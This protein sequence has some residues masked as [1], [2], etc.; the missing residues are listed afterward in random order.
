M[1]GRSENITGPYVDK[2][3]FK[4]IY[5]GG[6]PFLIGN[7]DWPGVGH[8]GVYTFDNQDYIIYH[9]YDAR[10]HG[11][12]KLM[13]NKLGWDEDGWPKVIKE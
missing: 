1:V 12:P 10:D 7:N 9:A 11:K 4:M 5:G 2:N 8:N 13:I 3:G 6:S